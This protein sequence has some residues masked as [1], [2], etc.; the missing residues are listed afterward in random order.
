MLG[1]MAGFPWGR[2]SSVCLTIV[3][4]ALSVGCS[5]SDGSDCSSDSDCPEGHR[6]ASA[7]GVV[8][9]GERVCVARA[10]QLEADAG[11][12][13]VADDTGGSDT[14]CTGDDCPVDCP[15]DGL[16]FQKVVAGNFFSCGLSNQGAA[17]CWGRNEFG[18]L[19]D[20]AAAAVSPRPVRVSGDYVDI[21]AAG[22]FEHDSHACALDEGGRVHC[23]GDNGYGQL[24]DGTTTSRAL[25][26]QVSGGVVFEALTSGGANSCGVTD[27][28]RAFCW[29]RN[30]T[31]AVGDG[32][33]TERH[34]PTRVDGGFRFASV[35][36]GTYHGC[37]VTTADAV[38]CWGHNATGQL[39]DGSTVM[40][41]VPV[42]LSLPFDVRAV[43]AGFQHSCALSDDGAAYCWGGNAFGQ[44]GDASPGEQSDTP[45]A[46]AGDHSFVDIAAGSSFTCGLTDAGMVYCWGQI[47]DDDEPTAIASGAGIESI[48]AGWDHICGVDAA[49]RAW[50]W[51][52]NE[53]GQIGDGSTDDRSSPTAVVCPAG[54]QPQ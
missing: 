51:G 2:C 25:P 3:A 38:V 26:N 7:G 19:G 35:S 13:D 10:G 45:V 17:Y 6:C 31:G 48:S 37:G 14:G 34:V 4:V 18:E 54:S 5:L 32:S 39:G 49:G 29:G 8:F 15:A 41:L 11:D 20:R 46:V 28:Q 24:G 52:G 16:R 47:V 40:R 43:T 50:C 9:G 23:W 12:D 30:F 36:A 1:K 27:D 53:H 33:D 22:D 44:L 42:E 21:S